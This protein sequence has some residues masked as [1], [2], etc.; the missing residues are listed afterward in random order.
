MGLIELEAKL[1]SD[2]EK[3]L[4]EIKAGIDSQVAS[5]LAE[6]KSSA[7]IDGRRI[8]EGGERKARLMASKILS[9]AK[10]KCARAESRGKNLAVE[11]VFAEASRRVLAMPDA[12][13]AGFLLKLFLSPVF[14]GLKFQAKVDKKYFPLVKGA[15]KKH[16][17]EA[18]LGDFGV[19]L[20][21]ADGLIRVDNRISSMMERIKPKI[22]KML[23][24]GE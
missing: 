20:E 11:E 24:G 14:E 17:V 18:E 1:R 10:A 7:E 8:I 12:R 4:Q 19:M 15:G 13:K 23:F 6:I 21:S 16:V 22:A 2:A 9:D 5:I 3:E